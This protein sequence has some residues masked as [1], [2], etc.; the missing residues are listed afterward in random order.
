MPFPALGDELHPRAQA[1]Y[2][3]N[4]G[5]TNA[6]TSAFIV[7]AN[8][9]YRW[10][11]LDQQT[12]AWATVALDP[13][14]LS[15]SNKLKLTNARGEVLPGDVEF[16]YDLRVNAPYY[17]YVDYAAVE[18]FHMSDFYSEEIAVVTNRRDAAEGP[19]PSC[20]TDW[21]VRLREGKSDYEGLDLV[22]TG[23]L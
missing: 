2:Y 13:T 15:A 7:S 14:A 5:D 20:G 1:T 22:L 11:Y 19:L 16:W 18:G 12:N 21:F 4:P 17:A 8:L 10:R 3:T 23:D 6:D 9:H